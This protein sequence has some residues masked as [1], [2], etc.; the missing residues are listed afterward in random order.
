M[1]KPP[2]RGLPASPS[3]LE[4]AFLALKQLQDDLQGADRRVLAGRLE[5]VSGWLGSNASLRDALSQAV[6]ASAEDKRAADQAASI[7]EAALQ[8][9]R[10]A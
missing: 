4:E 8:D 7:H 3:A 1:T 2:A 6:A 10:A 9:T 5:L